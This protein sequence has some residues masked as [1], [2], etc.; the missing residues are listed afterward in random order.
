MVE[1]NNLFS[2]TVQVCN[3]K[4]L[5]LFCC[6]DMWVVDVHNQGKILDCIMATFINKWDRFHANACFFKISIFLI[7]SRN[8]KCPLHT[9]ENRA[10]CHGVVR[11]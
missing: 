5:I 6:T 8:L 7:Y 9:I 3:I 2:T 4:W 11:H 1:Q 10:I